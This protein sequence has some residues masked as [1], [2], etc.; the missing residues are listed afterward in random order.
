VSHGETLEGLMRHFAEQHDPDNVDFWGLVGLLHDLDWE[1]WPDPVQHTVKT[2]ELLEEAGA[3]PE[4]ARAIQTHNSDLNQEL[5]RP[6]R[7][8]EKWLY[9]ADELSGLI[10][11]AAKMRPSRSVTDMELKSL[12]KKFKD[13]RFAAGCNRDQI[14]HGAELLDMELDELLVAVLDAMKTIAPVGDIYAE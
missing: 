9:A 5:P 6:E 14:R 3:T 13:K 12:K 10:Q 2:A 11:A 4:L 7:A 8:M 1:K